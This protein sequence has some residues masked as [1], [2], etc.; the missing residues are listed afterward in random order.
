ME[1]ER[2][3]CKNQRD[4]TDDNDINGGT[5]KWLGKEEC[6]RAKYKDG[7]REGGHTRT[8]VH[9]YTHTSAHT[10]E[11]IHKH[12]HKSERSSSHVRSSNL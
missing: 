12:K 10:K 7:V 6:K 4:N 8:H 2:G 1:R 3:I 5:R 9:I 11:D